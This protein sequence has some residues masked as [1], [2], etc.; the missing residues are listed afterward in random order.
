MFY[1]IVKDKEITMPKP[2]GDKCSVCGEK[3]DPQSYP[4]CS[5]CQTFLV[6]IEDLDLSPSADLV[7]I[8]RKSDEYKQ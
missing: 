6:E 2:I 3:F 5:Y 1:G 4:F 7:T 8:F